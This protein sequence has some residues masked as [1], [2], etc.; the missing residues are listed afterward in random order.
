MNQYQEKD[1]KYI[2]HP[3]AQMKDYEDLPPI[4]IEKGD[5]I[6]IYDVEGNK[7]IDCISSWWANLFGHSN[8][9]INKAIWNQVNNIEHVIFANFSNKPAIELA[10]KLIKISPERLK[11]VYFADNGS[12]AVETALKMSFQYHQQNGNTSKTRFASIT[13]AYHGET[14]GALSVGDLDL[15]SKIYNPLLL[16]TLRAEGPDCYRCSYGKCRENCHAE[17]FESMEN[18]ILKHHKE[19]CGIII[20]PMVQGAAGMKIYS[21]FYL[22]KLRKICDDYNI[23][24]IADEIAMG[25][26]RTGKMF[27]CNHANISPDLM[28]LSKGISAG[29]MPLSAVLATEDIYNAFY[30]DYTELKAFIHSHTYAGNAMACAIACESLKIFEEEKVLEKNKEKGKL[31]KEKVLEKSKNNPYIGDVRSIGMI[32]AIEIVQNKETKENFP[33][34]QRVGYEIYKI[35][36]KKGLLLRPI[37]NVLYFIPPYI[38]EEIAQLNFLNYI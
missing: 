28:C 3:C 9:R 24:I 32:T 19:I 7:Y 31:I 30:G 15:Y 12:S 33:W 17:C 29:Y 23:H 35:A 8:K 16:N 36:L 22:K 5:G 20:E 26:G 1:L 18:L 11:K 21:H 10:E 4:V 14:L 27:A 38:I 37:G 6:Y 2:W 13:N 25:F 34:E